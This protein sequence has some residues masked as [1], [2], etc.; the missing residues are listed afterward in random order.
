MVRTLDFQSKN[1]SSNLASPNISSANTVFFKKNNSNFFLKLKKIK[2]S[3]SFVSYAPSHFIL[4]FKIL[5][6]NINDNKKKILVKQS[7]ILLTWFYYFSLINLNKKKK[8][9]FSYLP[10]KKKIFTMTKGPMAHKN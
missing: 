8:I 5:N 7:Y 1:A 10:I 4:N 2:L 6:F 3:F 9:N